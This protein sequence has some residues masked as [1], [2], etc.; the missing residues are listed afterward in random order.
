MHKIE[1][2]EKALNVDFKLKFVTSKLSIEETLSGT[3][4][5]QS[6]DPTPDG[7]GAYYPGNISTTI[8][9]NYSKVVVKSVSPKTASATISLYDHSTG[10]IELNITSV[11][12]NKGSKKN[13]T[14]VTAKNESIEDSYF[15]DFRDWSV[16]EMANFEKIMKKLNGLPITVR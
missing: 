15:E 5:S 12:L 2:I 1:E 6:F 16:F 11:I 13:S 7:T 14:N 8:S 10:A 4:G 9:S 3:T